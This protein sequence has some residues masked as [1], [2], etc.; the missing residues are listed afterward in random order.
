[1]EIRQLVASEG[2]LTIDQEILQEAKLTGPLRLFVQNGEIRIVRDVVLEE[3]EA[4]DL[5]DE[6]AG[7]L[8]QEPAEDYNFDL[9]IGSLYEAR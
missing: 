6:L 2:K 1:M 9:K 3:D 7:C 5:L 4:L 8:G